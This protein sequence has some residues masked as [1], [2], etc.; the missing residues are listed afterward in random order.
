MVRHFPVLHFQ[1]VHFQSPRFQNTFPYYRHCDVSASD[2]F[3]FLLSQMSASLSVLSDVDLDLCTASLCSCRV[4]LYHA[5]SL[6][7]S[8]LYATE[9]N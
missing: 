9:A 8:F 5:E 7:K 6:H 2:V 1:V 3:S 4:A